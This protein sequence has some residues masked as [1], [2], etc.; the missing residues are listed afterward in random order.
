MQ[1]DDL[2]YCSVLVGVIVALKQHTKLK[3]SD[4]H[5]KLSLHSALETS[6]LIKELTEGDEVDAL[7]G[8]LGCWNREASGGCGQR[9]VLRH[10]GQGH[11]ESTLPD[12]GKHWAHI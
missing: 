10:Q 4:V 6:L 1:R 11:K 8:S 9:G 12:A 3:S 7:G 2:L 5:L